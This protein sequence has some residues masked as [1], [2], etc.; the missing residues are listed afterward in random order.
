MFPQPSSSRP[1][2]CGPSV[3]GRSR[4]ARPRVVLLL[5]LIFLLVAA[6]TA[7]AH[8]SVLPAEVPPDTSQELTIRVPNEKSEPT[9]RVRVELPTGFTASRF[10]PIPARGGWP[11]SSCWWEWPACCPGRAVAATRALPGG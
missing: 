11:G 8:V 4:R 3:I 9:V 5:S 6:S 7:S 10:E 2:C 1:T